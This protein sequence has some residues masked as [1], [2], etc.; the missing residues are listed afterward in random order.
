MFR[1]MTNKFVEP[2]PTRSTADWEYGEMALAYAKNSTGMPGGIAR[3]F[4]MPTAD[5]KGEIAE[6]KALYDSIYTTE[7]SAAIPSSLVVGAPLKVERT[8]K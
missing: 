6:L 8:A 3:L 2:P 5:N 1:G 4:A 7:S